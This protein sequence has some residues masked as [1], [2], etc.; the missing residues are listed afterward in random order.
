MT[1]NATI[2]MVLVSLQLGLTGTLPAG[3]EAFEMTHESKAACSIVVSTH[4][5]PAVRLAA[6]ELQSHLLK[7]SGAE[8]PI[9]SEGEPVA[10]RRILVGESAATRHLGLRG[11]DFK[12]QEYLISFR[13]NAV[14]LIGRDWEDTEANRRV[15]GRPMEGDTL[16]SLRHK[17]DYW[18]AVGY[19]ARSIGETELPGLY[20]DQGTCLAVYDF[21]ERFCGVRW[22]G[23]SELNVVLP[24]RSSVS[25]QGQDVR[26]EPG[27]KHRSAMASGS[28][29]FLRG[30]WGEFTQ[31][32]LRLYWRRMRQ[33]GE[34]WAGNHTFHRSTIQS[35]FKDPEYQSKN[36]RTQG[37]QLCY[38]N[39]KLINQ[40]AQMARDYFDGKGQ[41][42]E[43]W[44][45][46]GDY[47][48]IV[49]DDNMN[50]CNCARCEALLAPSRSRKTGFFS[51]GEMSDYWFSFVNAVAREVRK[52]HP[53]KYIATLAYWAYAL[54]PSFDLEPNVSVAPCLHT[55]YYPVHPE[56]RANDS[57][58]YKGW[59]EK[60]GAPMFLW[61][62]YHHPMEPA[63]IE[64]WKCFP[65]VMVHQ[66]AK[67]MQRFIHDGV[68]GIFECGEQ[69]QLEQ[70]VMAKVWDDPALDVDALIDE[71]FKGCFG[72]AAE[73]MK[74]F[75]LRLEA[76]ACDQ[77]NYPPPYH[78]PDGIAWKK[79]AWERL[80]TAERMQELGALMTEAETRAGTEKEKRR[81]ALWRSA[82]WQWMVEGREQFLAAEAQKGK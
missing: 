2:L 26:R 5:T 20:D 32:Q 40:V 74:R 78:R 28:W 63:L 71:F 27:L 80:G 11:E 51:S 7:I 62:Y 38:S 59:R 46:L 55:C 56:M 52:T 50:L 69:D 6:L 64:K 65:H 73:P 68:R 30:Q 9:V 48:A 76:I 70:Y 79:V 15:E 47:F 24:S 1:R 3:A 36:P 29:P 43:G 75:Y 23:P 34:P 39:P 33:G 61:V 37:S 44:K 19:P 12:P 16:A 77:S 66:T 13:S 14:V 22:Y 18:K 45:A 82:L 54:P 41:L 8:I 81:V 58:F 42:P 57:Q 35:T 49:P 4:P 17:V 21:L 60:T 72:A 53:N 31:D 25:I 67:A 10:G